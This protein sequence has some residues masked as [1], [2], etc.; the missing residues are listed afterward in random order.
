MTLATKNR[1]D[2]VSGRP[3]R[4]GYMAIVVKLAN[5]LI[6]NESAKDEVAEYLNTLGEDW[7]AFTDGELKKSNDANTKS[8]GGQQPRPSLGDDDDMEGSMSMDSIL[9]R[10]TNFSNERSKRETSQDDDDDDD[11]DDNEGD[12]S[13]DK[14]TAEE[15]IDE[16]RIKIMQERDEEYQ[17]EST[18]PIIATDI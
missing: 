16:D 8:L 15:L 2:H 14:P 7:K 9:S 4:H 10:F 17:N 12:E 18:L 3:I 11:D 5:L 6:K 13:N 1:F